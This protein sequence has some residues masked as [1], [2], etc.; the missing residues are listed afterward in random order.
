METKCF[1]VNP[2]ARGAVCKHCKANLALRERRTICTE[3]TQN[4]KHIIGY[5]MPL[6]NEDIYVHFGVGT[7][8]AM[9]CQP[10]PPEDTQELVT[11]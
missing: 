11:L 6:K 8:E 2:D 7:A 1:S 10:C 3:E 4:G 5:W 9:G